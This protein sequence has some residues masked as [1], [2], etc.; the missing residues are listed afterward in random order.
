MVL[1]PF[2]PGPRPGQEDPDDRGDHPDGGHDQRED[3]PGLAE[4][5]LPQNERGDQGDRVGL[6]NVRCHPGA[7]A[8]VVTDISAMA[9]AFRGSSS[10]RSGSTLPTRSAPT[11]AALVKIPPPTR[12]KI[13]TGP[14]RS[15]SRQDGGR[16]GREY[17]EM[18]VPPNKPS[19]T[20]AMP[21]D[22][23]NGRRSHC[24]IGIVTAGSGADPDVAPNCHLIPTNPTSA[25]NTA[26][27]RNATERAIRRVRLAYSCSHAPGSNSSRK[28]A[29]TAKTLRVRNCRREVRACPL[30]HGAGDQLHLRGA[31]AGRQH[32]TAEHH[33]HHQG[34]YGDDPD[35]GD[36]GQVDPRQGDCGDFQRKWK[37]RHTDVLSILIAHAHGTP[38]TARSITRCATGLLI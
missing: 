32:L 30:L 13:A 12:M 11:S 25:E 5:G 10:G 31:V 33:R 23:R 9:A 28:N 17:E 14:R 27:A 3:Q 4:C 29:A 8:H 7:V 38:T 1:R 34:Q 16:V 2:S 24:R 15:R 35:D 21:S 20:V 22:R 26:P 6:E 36:E 18:I 37:Y 19:P